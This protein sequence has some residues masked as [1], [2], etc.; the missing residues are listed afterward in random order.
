MTAPELPED[1][2]VHFGDGVADRFLD[3]TDFALLGSQAAGDRLG[4]QLD[5]HETGLFAGLL[6][7]HPIGHDEEIGRFQ[8]QG[9]GIAAAVMTI[10]VHGV[11]KTIVPDRV[12]GRGRSNCLRCDRGNCLGPRPPRLSA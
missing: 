2:L 7:T 3:P 4:N 8:R 12:D 5:R 11:V 10:P 6:A 1:L 9:R